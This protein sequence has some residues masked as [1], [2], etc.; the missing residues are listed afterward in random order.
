[1]A[2]R[3]PSAAGRRGSPRDRCVRQRFVRRVPRSRIA[4]GCLQTLHSG[5]G[6]SGRICTRCSGRVG[7]E[8]EAYGNVRK[9]PPRLAG[10]D[11]FL[12]SWLV[13]YRPLVSTR[14]AQRF[15][16]KGVR[17]LHNRC[18]LNNRQRSHSSDRQRESD[19][20]TLGV[21]KNPSSP[22]PKKYNTNA[23]RWPRTR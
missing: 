14:A 19:N 3:R 23:Q 7:G 9:L 8:T 12:L 1:M 15:T 11:L 22:A 17:Y 10:R 13:C 4:R 2:A 18:L 6:S 21:I 16:G 20:A 5:S